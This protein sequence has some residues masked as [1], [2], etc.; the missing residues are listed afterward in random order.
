MCPRKDLSAN[1]ASDGFAV[2]TML[3]PSRPASA[4]SSHGVSSI[5]ADGIVAIR[6]RSLFS[7]LLQ[8]VALILNRAGDEIDIGL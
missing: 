1:V 7:S 2:T 6:V 5:A 8:P 3:L 4:M